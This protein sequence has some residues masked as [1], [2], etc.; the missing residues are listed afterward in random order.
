VKLL[1]AA[2]LIYAAIL[3]TLFLASLDA[4]IRRAGPLSWRQAGSA[5][6]SAVHL[7][8]LWLAVCPLLVLLALRSNNALYGLPAVVG[9]YLAAALPAASALG[10][11]Q[12]GRGMKLAIA[13]GAT[14]LAVAAFVKGWRAHSVPSEEKGVALAVLREVLPSSDQPRLAMAYWGVVNAYSLADVAAFDL[15]TRVTIDDTLPWQPP[16]RAPML[17]IHRAVLWSG[18]PDLPGVE[19]LVGELRDWPFVLIL[20]P[21]CGPRPNPMPFASEAP[22]WY[23]LSEILLGSGDYVVVQAGLRPRAN[24]CAALLRRREGPR[25][26]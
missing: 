23:R 18:G 5:L 25:G 24:E 17:R 16:F 9:L 21:T 22:N 13:A 19:R 4:A 26:T 10:R 12:V 20:D 6:K 2:D 7:P 14:V 15:G 1:L 8:A 11:R 3:C